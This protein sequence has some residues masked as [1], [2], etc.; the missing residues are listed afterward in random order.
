MQTV[1]KSTIV[2]VLEDKTSQLFVDFLENKL[3]LYLKTQ[4]TDNLVIK[5]F[6]LDDLEITVSSAFYRLGALSAGCTHIGKKL[7]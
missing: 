7:F 1:L 4:G 3:F 5:Q 2:A 6:F